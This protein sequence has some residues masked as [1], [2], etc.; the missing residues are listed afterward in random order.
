MGSDLKVLK[1]EREIEG[2]KRTKVD[3]STMEVGPVATRAIL[4]GGDESVM[5]MGMDIA[6]PERRCKDASAADKAAEEEEE[7]EEEEAEEDGTEEKVSCIS[8]CV[9]LLRGRAPTSDMWDTDTRGSKVLG[10]DDS[11]NTSSGPQLG[12]LVCSR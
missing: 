2:E 5:T 10:D 11:E 12:F 1:K 6:E 3:D 7:E 8:P 9:R 4:L